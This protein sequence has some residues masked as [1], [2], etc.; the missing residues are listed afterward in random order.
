M[1][2]H[3]ALQ[4]FTALLPLSQHILPHI[5]TFSLQ[6]FSCFGLSPG[7]TTHLGIQLNLFSR[8][9]YIDKN[10]FTLIASELNTQTFSTL[11]PNR[12]VK[13]IFD[14]PIISQTNQ[15]DFNSITQS[16][17]SWI[18]Q[19]LH[20]TWLIHYRYVYTVLFFFKFKECVRWFAVTFF[21]IMQAVQECFSS[22]TVLSVIAHFLVREQEILSGGLQMQEKVSAG[23]VRYKIELCL[24]LE[25]NP[26]LIMGFHALHFSNN[27]LPSSPIPYSLILQANIPD[28]LLPLC[29]QSPRKQFGQTVF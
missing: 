8:A 24:H 25:W 9:G 10:K 1:H 2:S 11:L 28:T 6:I 19:H 26:R 4:L 5:Q 12:A 17:L 21:L 13:E 3:S 27:L 22:T 20:R 23:K 18:S 16:N 15:L 14:L 7:S 29:F